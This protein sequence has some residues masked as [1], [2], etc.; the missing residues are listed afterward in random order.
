MIELDCL[1]T[2][3]L[4]ALIRKEE[5]ALQMLREVS[6]DGVQLSTTIICAC[7]LCSGAYNSSNPNRELERVREVLSALEFLRWTT[8]RVCDLESLRTRQKSNAV[9]LVT[10]IY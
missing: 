7:E 5:K 2:S 1:D 4:V 10:L 3:V 6:V 8:V 9:L